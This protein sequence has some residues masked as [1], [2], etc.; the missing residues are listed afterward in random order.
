MHAYTLRVLSLLRLSLKRLLDMLHTTV[1]NE[2]VEDNF[3]FIITVTD[4]IDA[5]SF[6]VTKIQEIFKY[7]IIYAFNTMRDIFGGSDA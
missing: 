3:I 2:Y 7:D 1:Y 4:I 5:L 6:S